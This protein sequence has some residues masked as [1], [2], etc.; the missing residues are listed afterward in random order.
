MFAA[1]GSR[2]LRRGHAS[3]RPAQN[4]FE[5]RETICSSGLRSGLPDEDAV[6]FCVGTLFRLRASGGCHEA[7]GRRGRYRKDSKEGGPHGEW[8]YDVEELTTF[9][10]RARMWRRTATRQAPLKII[11]A[12]ARG[13]PIV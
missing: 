4:R 7:G 6:T 11:E 13:V 2:I 5:E 3:A 8:H 9:Y 12:A 1:A 10:D